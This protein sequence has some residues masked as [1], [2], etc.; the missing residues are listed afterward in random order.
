MQFIRASN[1]T[2]VVAYFDNSNGIFPGDDVRIRGVNVGKID[3]IEPEPT[4][5]KISFWLDSEYAVPAD[6]KAVIV[7]PT[8]VT[9]RAVQL[10]PPYTG[11]ATLQ[12]DAVIPRSAPRFRWNGT[13]SAFSLNASPR[14]CSPP[15][16]AAAAPGSV[17]SH[18]RGQSPRSGP[19]DP[20]RGHQ[21]VPGTFGARRS[22]RRHLHQRQEHRNAG[23][24]AEGQRRTARDPQRKPRFGHRTA[25]GRAR[26][27][28][29]RRQRPQ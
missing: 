11:G 14:R 21:T 6:A 10:T 9:A 15:S 1:R 22:Q 23:D 26:R 12:N 24:R 8:L 18:R 7:S 16:L 20:G 5:V 25:R 4:R 28:R 29:R 17:G 19:S 13:T 3:K 27:G 2:H